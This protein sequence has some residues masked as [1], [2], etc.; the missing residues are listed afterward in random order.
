M[1]TDYSVMYTYI[2]LSIVLCTCIYTCTSGKW[3]VFLR[4]V[5]IHIYGAFF[6]VMYMNIYSY[7]CGKQEMVTL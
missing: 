3:Q 6:S 2:V 5:R 7:G 4:K 1:C